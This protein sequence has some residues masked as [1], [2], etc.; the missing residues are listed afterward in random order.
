[1]EIIGRRRDETRPW[2][3]RHRNHGSG[4]DTFFNTRNFWRVHP[5]PATTASTPP[6]IIAARA[7]PLP[8]AI[9]DIV[10]Y[11]S[12]RTVN[13]RGITVIGNSGPD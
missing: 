3:K 9:R 7:A 6:R 4:T 1:M 11:N 5:A 10:F 8:P 13:H 12:P 2:L